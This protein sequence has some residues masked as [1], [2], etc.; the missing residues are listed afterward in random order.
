MLLLPPDVSVTYVAGIFRGLTLV[1]FGVD[2][3]GIGVGVTPDKS[4]GTGP[5]K[6]PATDVGETSGRSRIDHGLSAWKII[7]YALTPALK[8]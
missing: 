2:S 6:M 4:T 1:Q 7:R 3:R 5:L 8:V